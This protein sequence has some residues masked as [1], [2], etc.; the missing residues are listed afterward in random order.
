[1]QLVLAEMG[2]WCALPLRPFFFAR[3][4][5][6]STPKWVLILALLYFALPPTSHT[7]ADAGA[8]ER[9]VCKIPGAK[10]VCKVVYHTYEYC[11]A[12]LTVL[13]R[14]GGIGPLLSML[15][16][17]LQQ[18]SDCREKLEAVIAG[19]STIFSALR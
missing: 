11:D 7:S 3:K 15:G 10:Q 19:A 18:D 8:L 17:C 5:V 13:L 12:Y 9:S 1:M 4:L 2:G 14:G 6:Q 16:T